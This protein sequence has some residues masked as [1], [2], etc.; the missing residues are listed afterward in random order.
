MK[1]FKASMKASVNTSCFQELSTYSDLS[2]VD[3]RF[4]LSLTEQDGDRLLVQ[5]GWSET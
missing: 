3:G 4:H 2:P 1:L 5:I